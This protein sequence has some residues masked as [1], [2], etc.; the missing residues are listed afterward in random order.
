MGAYEM[1]SHPE[2]PPASLAENEGRVIL[3][4]LSLLN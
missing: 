2:L 3:L 1:V 4:N